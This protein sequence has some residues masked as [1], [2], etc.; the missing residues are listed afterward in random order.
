MHK[1]IKRYDKYFITISES[2]TMRL[3]SFDSKKT[4]AK[5]LKENYNVKFD[6]SRLNTHETKLMLNKVRKLAMEARKESN[7]YDIKTN[8]SYMK[9]VFMEQALVEHYNILLRNPSAKIIVEASKVEE[10][11]V[12]LAAQEIVDSVQKMIVDVSDTLVKELPALVQSITSDIGVNQ[13]Q[14]YEQKVTE[15][16]KNLSAQL[17]QSKK[18]LEQ[19]LMI[20]EGK[21]VGFQDE[22]EP[23][24]GMDAPEP[25]MDIP[26]APE[27]AG[28]EELDDFEEPPETME[29]PGAGRSKR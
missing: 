7:F 4:A 12:Y 25:D 22:T 9:L 18:E 14:Q 21:D 29:I 24:M 16:L 10:S 26:P 15:T 28:D 3:Q 13:G 27:I 19:A 1:K 23:D 20:I 17:D 8:P 6:T 11:Q 2:N 5:A